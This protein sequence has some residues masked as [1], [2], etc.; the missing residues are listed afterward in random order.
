MPNVKPE[1]ANFKLYF[2]H[3]MNVVSSYKLFMDES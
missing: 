3:R 2:E 1:Y